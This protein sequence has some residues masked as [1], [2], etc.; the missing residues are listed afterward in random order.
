MKTKVSL[1]NKQLIK[2][3][4]AAFS[5]ISTVLSII[6]IFVDIPDKI[7]FISFCGFI[8]LLIFLYISNWIRANKILSQKLHIN[9]STVKIKIGDIFSEPGLKAIAFNEYFDTQVDE[10]IIA[11]TTLN[12]K[13]IQQKNID[14]AAL[15]T[16]IKNDIYLKESIIEENTSRKN[17][18]TIRYKLGSILLYEQEYILTAFSRFDEKNKAYLTIQD[19]LEFLIN[20]WTDVDKVYA[21]RSVTIPLFGSGITRFRGY[22]MINDQELLE[23]LIWSF[24]ISRIK[25]THPAQVTILINPDKKGQI[26]FYDLKGGDCSVL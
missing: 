5:L 19:Y 16:L 17:G 25:I 1:L 8:I 21:G 2:Q 15:D 18:K 12:G 9:N 23:I 3:F 22:E 13:F 4:V 26:N 10:D 24:K 20:F 11:S 6:L 7:K 14:V